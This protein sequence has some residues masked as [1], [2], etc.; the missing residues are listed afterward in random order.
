METMSP[1][2]NAYGPSILNAACWDRLNISALAVQLLK[3]GRRG[4]GRLVTTL[5]ARRALV[6]MPSS[7]RSC[8]SRDVKV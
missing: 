8:Y 5:V 6:S 4:R 2:R 7:A 1:Q 3:K